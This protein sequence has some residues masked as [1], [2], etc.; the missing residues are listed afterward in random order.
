M[1]QLGLDTS[2]LALTKAGTA[3]YLAK[4]LEGLEEELDLELH[5]YTWGGAGRVTKVARDLFWYPVGLPRASRNGGVDVLHCPTMRAPL[6]PKAP[7]VVT[8]H[9]VAVLRHPEAFNGWRRRYI[10][11]TLPRVAQS[12][13]A[14]AVGSAFPRA[15]PVALL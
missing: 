14:I 7:L 12:A 9:D 6:R 8:I 10:A 1:L 3:R 11:R 15:E 2:P 4:L 5:R 13:S